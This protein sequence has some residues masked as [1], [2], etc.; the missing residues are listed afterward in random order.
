MTPDNCE[1]QLHVGDAA[2]VGSYFKDTYKD[3]GEVDAQH[4][5]Q[6]I[7]ARNACLKGGD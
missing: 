2:I 5:K 3:H 1:K 4:V 7:S 6:M